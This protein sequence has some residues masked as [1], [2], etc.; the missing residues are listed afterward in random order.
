MGIGELPGDE[1][2]DATGRGDEVITISLLQKQHNLAETR[3]HG[4]DGD[5]FAALVSVVCW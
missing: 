5:L 4:D 1:G 2:A 3:G